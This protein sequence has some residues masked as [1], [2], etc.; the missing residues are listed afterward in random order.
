MPLHR[1]ASRVILSSVSVV[2]AGSF[3]LTAAAAKVNESLSVATPFEVGESP[4]GNYLAAVIA[5]ADRDTVAAATFFREALRF[6]PRNKELIER[7]FVAALSNG[8]MPE[9]FTLADKLL[10]YEPDNGL[11]RLA[12]GVRA[13]KEHQYAAARGQFARGGGAEGGD[14]TATLLT[15]WAY[16]GSGQTRR[17]L[18]TVDRLDDQNFSV[19]RSYHKALIADVAGRREQAADAFKAAYD[20]DKNTL[21]LVD[22]YA[23]FLSQTGKDDQAIALYTAF[24][25]IVPDHPI[26]RAALASLKGGKSLQPLI[27][28]VDQ[29]A[30]EV[31]YGLGAAGDRQGDDLA[32]LIYLRLSLYLDPDNALALLTLG[33][34]YQRINQNEQA[35]DIFQDVPQSDPQRETADIEIS[36]ALENLGRGDQA[37]SYLRNVADEHPNDEEAL[38]A[39]GNLERAHDHYDEAI[40]T[41]TRALA[42]SKKPEAANWPLYYFRGIAYERSKQWPK[43]E[44]DFKHALQLFP[45]QPLVLNYLGYSWVD[46][47]MHLDQAFP[48]L[49]RAVELRPTDGYVV[50]SLGWAEYKLGHYKEAVTDLEKAID[51]KPADPVINDHLGDA[52]WRVGRKLDA[53]FQWNHARDMG[54]DSTDLPRILHKIKFGLDT[55][56]SA[57]PKPVTNDKPAAADADHKQNGGG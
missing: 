31:L 41:Y 23:R 46:K 21:R 1:L 50:D 15:A 24:D 2:L 37:L 47:G 9:A 5:G 48:M 44:A 18:E 8:S 33:D 52:Y 3:G 10:I 19:F 25:Q 57:D 35:L 39:L 17:A 54:A 29:G 28:N 40:T 16:Q 43:A 12:V 13:L 45:D 14:L 51:L 7:A 55:A 36:Q 6:D 32:G 56:A 49:R 26:V 38:S 53:H 42:A 20:S 34:L 27:G 30:A 22:A 4:A 11:A